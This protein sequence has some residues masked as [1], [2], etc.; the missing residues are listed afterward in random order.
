ML[1]HWLWPTLEAGC[2]CVQNVGNIQCHAISTSECMIQK[3][4]FK[5]KD[6]SHCGITRCKWLALHVWK[7]QRLR[8]CHILYCFGGFHVSTY[9]HGST[10]VVIFLLSMH[11]L[12]TFGCLM[13]FL[14]SNTFL[15]LEIMESHY[16]GTCQ[17][18]YDICIVSRLLS[19]HSHF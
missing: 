2:S 18:H 15:P 13:N 5:I 1:F 9:H 17:E 4:Q 10:G 14:V 7:P 11:E 12:A 8:D 16:C 19:S 6:K 3:V